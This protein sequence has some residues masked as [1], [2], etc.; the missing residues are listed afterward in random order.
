MNMLKKLSTFDA[1]I[2]VLMAATGLAIKPVI[3]PLLKII[4]S[5]FLISTGSIAGIVYM[6]FPM[7]ALLIVRQTGT[8]TLTGLIQG[9]IV[10][11]VGIYG[12]HGILSLLTYSVPGIFIDLGF[13]LI[14]QYR[15]K[16]LLFIPTGLG[17]LSGSW[18]VGV[19]FL[20]LPQI[21]LIISLVLG[22]ILG[23]ISGYLSWYLY[24]WLIQT[25]PLLD[26]GHFNFE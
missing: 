25:V 13:L 18:L 4:G 23:G 11:I 3:G 9:V 19:L 8:A 5:A 15:K 10:M 21:P 24:K 26:K 14:R 16:W 17:N 2:V 12:S 6:I 7:L 1:V 22:F 20:R